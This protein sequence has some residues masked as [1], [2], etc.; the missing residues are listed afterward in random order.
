MEAWQVKSNLETFGH[1][2]TAKILKKKKIPFELAYF[3]IFGR[4]PRIV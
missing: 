1:F 3:L 4:Y 2:D